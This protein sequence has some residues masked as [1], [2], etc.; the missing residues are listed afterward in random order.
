MNYIVD[1]NGFGNTADVPMHAGGKAPKDVYKILVGSGYKDIFLEDE[2]SKREHG[3][4]LE[5]LKMHY[6]VYMHWNE[7][8]KMLKKD[9]IVVIQY[10]ILNHTLFFGLLERKLK[11]KGIKIIVIIHDLISLRNI[12]QNEVDRMQKRLMIEEKIL[13]KN[14][15]MLIAHNSKMKK[16]LISLGVKPHQIKTLGIFDYLI[17]G[18]DKRKK[19]ID[20]DL[21]G[22]PVVIAGNL[23]K[24]K[25]GYVYKLPDNMK[26]NLY[27]VNYDEDEQKDN[28]VY[29]GA[30]DPDELPYIM[31]G[32]FGLVWDGE[33]SDNCSGIYGNYLK[34]NNPH[35]V[36]LYIASCLPVII[37]D[38]AA[39]SEFVLKYK[40][41]IVID[42]LENLKEKISK[43]SMG[44]YNDM[45]KNCVKLSK[46]L[47][48]GYYTQ[49]ALRKIDK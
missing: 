13:L 46:R 19:I 49:K 36:S 21:I 32:G 4:V 39:M 14:A 2:T 25:A 7:K 47:Q 41:G 31:D 16:Y 40:C 45:K 22:Q 5:K 48:E 9:D 10:P 12:A 44:E 27:G 35:K 15:Y 1:E 42:N 43:I 34:Y 18:E 38:K 23:K 11:R 29:H 8:L 28:V 33:D 30:Y 6:T 37:W 3:N 24:E 26:F 17:S 20:S